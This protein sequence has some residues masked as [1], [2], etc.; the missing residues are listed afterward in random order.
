MVPTRPA[1]GHYGLDEEG[2]TVRWYINVIV[3]EKLEEEEEGL[4]E[5]QS[6]FFSF[7][8]KFFEENSNIY[9]NI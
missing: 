4:I 9:L 5:I 1:L 2:D 8:K 7:Y 3:K 6:F